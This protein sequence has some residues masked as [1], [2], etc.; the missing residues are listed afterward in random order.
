MRNER[1]P[2]LSICVPTYNRSKLLKASLLSILEQIE[3]REDDVELIVSDNCSTDD[4]ADVISSL[5]KNMNFVYHRNSEN[6][7]AGANFYLLAN[8]LA[9]GKYCWLIGDDDFLRKDSL[10][11][12]L[13]ILK[14]NTDV[15]VVLHECPAHNIEAG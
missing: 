2:L 11:R 13:E 15:D 14:T 7:G 3:G 4:T 10:G 1:N 9:R 6:I 12:L 8:E 5:Q